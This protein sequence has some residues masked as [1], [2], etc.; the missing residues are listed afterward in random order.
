MSLARRVCHDHAI[1]E[2]LGRQLDVRRLAAAAAGAA[3]FK[4]RL[5]G[6]LMR[7]LAGFDQAAIDF[8]QAEEE[9]PVG[10]SLSR[11]GG[12]GRML[13]A[14]RFAALLL[15]AGQTSTQMPQPVA[16]LRR[17]LNGVFQAV[18]IGIFSV[19]RF[20]GRR[21]LRQQLRLIG[22]D[23]DHGVW[24]DHG[25]LAALDADIRLPDWRS[26]GRGCASHAW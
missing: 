20:E 21:R 19:G 8:G 2:E 16:I 7:M 18:P 1:A 12:C 17:D 15:L 26:Q 13:M 25:A 14:R 4:E 22:F 10:A 5:L 9:F 23:A 3:E 24:A 11:S 6:L